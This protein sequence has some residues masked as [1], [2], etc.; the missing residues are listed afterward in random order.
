MNSFLLLNNEP[1]K[2]CKGNILEAI[3]MCNAYTHI[4]LFI[5]S[6]GS[7]LP[8]TVTNSISPLANALSGL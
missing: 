6:W 7:A 1:R 8:S 3:E 4:C 2:D 5:C